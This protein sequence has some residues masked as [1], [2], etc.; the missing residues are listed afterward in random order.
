MTLRDYQEAAVTA[1]Y[2]AWREH[3][4]VLVTMPTG[5]GKTI[6]FSAIAA[7]E[8]AAGRRTLILAH[9]DEL[10]QQAADKL[11]RSTGVLADVE[12]GELSAVD[13]LCQVTVGSVQT[14]MR[15]KRLEAY[16]PDAYDAIIVDEAHHCLSDSYQSILSYFAGAR[17]LGVTATPDRGDKRNL[18]SYFEA[19]AYE[20]GL[21]EAIQAGH[22]SRIVA[23]TIPLKIDLG[24]VRTT[25]GDYNDADL[26]AALEPYLAAIAE[27]IAEVACDRK[28]LVFLPLI[29]TS[30][31]MTELLREQGLAAAHIDG[32]SP[33]RRERLAD[34]HS[35]KYRV[36][37][38]SMLLTEG[39]DEPTVDCIVCLRPTKIRALYAQIVGRGTRPA[40]GKQDLLILDFL[41]HTSSHDLCHPAC[42][43]AKSAE[44]SD[45]LTEAIEGAPAPVDL[46]EGEAE[47]SESV[48]R[49]REEALAKKLREQSAKKSRLLDPVSFGLSIAAEDLVDYEPAFPW[50]RQ[51][52]S[53]RQ[54]AVLD[55]M[56]F[57]RASIPNKG[58]ASKLL[59]RLFSRRQENLATPRQLV[60]L[61]NAGVP[62]PEL[63]TFDQAKAALDQVSRHG[64]KWAPGMTLPEAPAKAT[65]PA[66]EAATVPPDDIPF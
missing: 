1:V 44:V 28:T 30:Q 38:N 2:D 31:R 46:L 60:T 64:W 59:D 51:P 50:E 11:V 42:L 10:I 55:R 56:G 37:C 9:R 54:L 16:A 13:S 36:L 14:L 53:E 45:K 61:R 23:Q 33:D 41:W 47:A 57:D 20:Y 63:L 39:Y 43:V 65:G 58:Y 21:R 18:G 29:A 12:K 3:R 5:T 49:E 15:R 34:F 7:R 8:N 48:L 26:G 40:P 6:V 25:A 62:Q 24:G 22:L 66:I 35:G 32:T 52:A 19:C 4:R 17:V 27:Q